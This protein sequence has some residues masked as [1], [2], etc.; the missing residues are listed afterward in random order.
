MTMRN[1]TM[2]VPQ[3]ERSKRTTNSYIGPSESFQI[4]SMNRN[5]PM[6]GGMKQSSTVNSPIRKKRTSIFGF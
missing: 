3:M 2:S 6:I 4:G 1:R 5:K